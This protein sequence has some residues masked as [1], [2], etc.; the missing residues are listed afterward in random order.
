GPTPVPERSTK[1]GPPASSSISSRALRAPDAP[2][3]NVTLI[4]A[5][6]PSGIDAVPPPPEN[7]TWKSP[8]VLPDSC[9][10]LMCKTPVP[11]LLTETT[12]SF[13]WPTCTW[14]KLSELE[15]TLN[16]GPAEKPR[17][18]TRTVVEF[19]S[20]KSMNRL[21]NVSTCV[22][23]KVRFQVT[24]PPG[25]IGG[26]ELD[27]MVNSEPGRLPVILIVPVDA[28]G[29]PGALTS[30]K[31][32]V[33]L[34]PTGTIPKSRMLGLTR[35]LAPARAGAAAPNRPSIARSRHAAAPW[36]ANSGRWPRRRFAPGRSRG[37]TG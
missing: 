37:C 4:A 16:V 22:G 11:V 1:C 3:A 5:L 29:K 10:L 33:E 8:G 15:L 31:L 28:N 24:E 13:T 32:W 14:P 26:T 27:W 21:L 6:P 7:C 23:W 17:T 36:R 25:M 18:V 2:G 9:R 19:G 34:P 35:R 20:W 30:V 12:R